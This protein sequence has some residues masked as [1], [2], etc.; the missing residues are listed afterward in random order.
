MDP[1][2]EICIE[3]LRQGPNFPMKVAHKTIDFL[4]LKLPRNSAQLQH[5]GAHKAGALMTSASWAANFQ[6]NTLL[7]WMRIKII[8]TSRFYKPNYTTWINF[9]ISLKMLFTSLYPLLSQ[10]K[11]AGKSLFGPLCILGRCNQ[12]WFTAWCSS[13]DLSSQPWEP[14]HPV[15]LRRCNVVHFVSL[16]YIQFSGFCLIQGYSTSKAS[17]RKRKISAS[18]YWIL[19]EY[20]SHMHPFSFPFHF[21]YLVL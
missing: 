7:T 4:G 12:I 20:T 19:L 8:W 6:F 11:L 21:H 2:R 1:V 18:Y 3:P 17:G 15:N 16:K 10:W 13:W 5:C 14:G 9:C